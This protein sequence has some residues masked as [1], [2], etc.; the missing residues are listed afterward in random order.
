MS[1]KVVGMDDAGDFLAVGD[2][3]NLHVV[4][5]GLEDEAVHGVA[6]GGGQMA[7]VV[8]GK[9]EGVAFPLGGEG[10][11]VG[12][13]LTANA[14]WI[15]DK[16]GRAEPVSEVAVGGVLLVEHLFDGVFRG[17]GENVYIALA[18]KVGSHLQQ[19]HS[20]A[21]HE[22]DGGEFRCGFGD[23]FTGDSDERLTAD[24]HGRLSSGRR[25]KAGSE[26]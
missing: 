17:R 12:R 24:F 4:G 16:E 23:G 5:V 20:T 1:A 25:E 19:L 21:G 14:V 15:W 26:K 2:V 9:G 8:G 3:V 7:H 13:Q 6:F 11:A 18:R 10:F 22:G